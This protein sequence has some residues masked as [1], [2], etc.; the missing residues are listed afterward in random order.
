MRRVRVGLYIVAT[1]VALAGCGEA[2]AIEDAGSGMDARADAAPDARRDDS[3]RPDTG[4]IRLPD[5]GDR[6]G[7]G[8]PDSSADDGGD[9]GADAGLGPA[10]LCFEALFGSGASAIDGPEY[11]RFGPTVGTHCFG[12]DHQ[13]IT[14]VER[15]V[16]L[17]DSVTVGT[18]PTLSSAYYRSVLA[19]EL[20]TRFGLEGGGL[21]WRTVNVLEGV[22]NVQTD[23]DFSSCAEWG[24]RTD[25]LQRDGTQIADCFPVAE[26]DARTLVVMTI[27]GND[28]ANIAEGGTDGH[29]TIDELWTQTM[30]FVQLMRDAVEW[31]VTPGRFPNGVFVVFANMFEFTDG[32]GDTESCPAAALAGIGAP[33]DDPTALADMVIWANEQY[34]DIAVSTGTDMIFMLEHFCGHGH[35]HDN[36]AAPCY[37]GPGTP[38]WFDLSCI[39]PNPTGHAVIADMFTAVID[40]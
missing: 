31:I 22:S 17:G 27:G 12:T 14:G 25:D 10:A 19:E 37:R 23:G 3:A 24:A 5:A 6:D 28:I 13:D 33:W 11:D 35:N 34:M 39:H 40:E 18:P 21:L 20:K 4:P 15:V 7:A 8:E 30:E 32:T 16:F 38:I 26:R 2:T 1:T 29:T 9:A 36:P